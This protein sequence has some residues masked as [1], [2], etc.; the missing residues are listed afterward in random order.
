MIDYEKRNFSR[1]VLQPKERLVTSSR[2][3]L[4]FKILSIKMDW[5]QRKES[6]Q[7]LKGFLIT[8]FQNILFS[9]EFL[10]YIYYF[11]LFTK[12][13]RGL[14]ITFVAHFLDA[15]SINTLS[16]DQ[17]SLSHLLPFS[18][19]QTISIFKFLFSQLMTS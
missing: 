4:F 18:R 17:V 10:A 5:V 19:Y 1:H 13:K 16:F 15:F 2:P 9:K 14:R 6:S 11:G 8:I 3:L 7:I 12:I